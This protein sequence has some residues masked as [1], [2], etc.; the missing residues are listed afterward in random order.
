MARTSRTPNLQA[1]WLSLALISVGRE[2][3]G[4]LI[5][6]TKSGTISQ[7]PLDF[8]HSSGS[9]SGRDKKQASGSRTVSGS[10]SSSMLRSQLPPTRPDVFADFA[11]TRISDQ[12]NRH[13]DFAVLSTPA[14]HPFRAAPLL[15]V[16]PSRPSLSSRSR[17]SAVSRPLLGRR[18]SL[19]LPNRSCWP[20]VASSLRNS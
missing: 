12:L 17:S 6:A 5:S 9:L 1:T 15:S 7:Y 2:S 10:R 14:W 16:H 8:Q 19:G 11:K 18:H 20:I 4:D 13:G 3:L